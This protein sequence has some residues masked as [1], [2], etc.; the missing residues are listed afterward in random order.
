MCKCI[1]I[2]REEK[3]LLSIVPFY[4]KIMQRAENGCT[5]EIL[6]SFTI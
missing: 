1:E 5:V 2:M 4:I 3:A 6:K